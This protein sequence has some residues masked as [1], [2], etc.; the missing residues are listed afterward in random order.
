MLSI[1]CTVLILGTIDDAILVH[2]E[3]VTIPGEKP[4]KRIKD[5]IVLIVIVLGFFLVLSRTIFLPRLPCTGTFCLEFFIPGIAP[6]AVLLYTHTNILILVILVP[7]LDVLLIITSII[8]NSWLPLVI[9]VFVCE[10]ELFIHYL[11]LRIAV[12]LI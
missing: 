4:T 3:V 1:L 5:R 12:I 9:P 2:D 11:L 8:G 7:I 10:A 6:V